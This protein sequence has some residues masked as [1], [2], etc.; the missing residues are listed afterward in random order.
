[1]RHFRLLVLAAVASVS[2]GLG[3]Y[4]ESGAGSGSGSGE[5]SEEGPA[6]SDTIY[7]ACVSDAQCDPSETC[8]DNVNVCTTECAEDRDCPEAPGQAQVC[9]DERC[10]VGCL[11]DDGTCPEGQLCNGTPGSNFCSPL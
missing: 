8:L 4:E 6:A 10:V 2:V 3:C 7:T 11:P 9:L 1:M 5:G